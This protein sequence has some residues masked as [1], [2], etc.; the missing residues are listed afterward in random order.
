MS[1]YYKL[2]DQINKQMINYNFFR[3]KY[4][5]IA[6]ELD[7]KKWDDFI[8]KDKEMK[9]W[10]T[11]LQTIIDTRYNEIIKIFNEG[12]AFTLTEEDFKK[13][14]EDIAKLMQV[15]YPPFYEGLSKI[16]ESNLEH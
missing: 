16:I 15:N 6:R 8:D 1:T 13:F 7:I 4:T 9:N 3:L 10:A 11:S 2:K 12:L 5:A 14:G